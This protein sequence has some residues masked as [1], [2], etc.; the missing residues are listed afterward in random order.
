MFLHF[1]LHWNNPEERADYVDSSGVIMHL[2]KQLR[3][4]DGGIMRV[5]QDDLTIP[6]GEKEA[7]YTG[8]CSS[9]CSRSL[10]KDD[11]KVPVAWNHM[12]GLG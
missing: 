8:V 12:H 4:F 2:T 5:G 10:I 11:I 6:P 1:K 3:P 7:V 9:E